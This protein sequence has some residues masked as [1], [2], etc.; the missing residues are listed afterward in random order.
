MSVCGTTLM[1]SGDGSMYG[2]KQ[3]P[4]TGM[5]DD[6]FATVSDSDYI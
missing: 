5:A 4:W 2:V 1:C 3:F 6:A